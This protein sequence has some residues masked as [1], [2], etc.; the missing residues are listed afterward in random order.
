MT[1]NAYAKSKERNVAFDILKLVAM[2]MVVI[3]H[4]TGHGMSEASVETFSGVYWIQK[5]LN[6]FSMVAVNCFVLISGYFLSTKTISMKRILSLYIQVWSY[7]LIIYL[8]FCFIPG[9]NVDFSFSTLIGHMCPLLS[10]QYWFFTCYFLMYLLVPILNKIVESLEHEEYKKM[11][12]TLLFLFSAIPSINIW[13]DKFGTSNGYSLIWFVVLYLIA[14]YVRKFECSCKYIKYSGM[15]Y[16]VSCLILV[17]LRTAV[18]AINTEHG[19]IQVLLGNQISY[20]GPLVLLASV[21]LLL[22]AKNSRLHINGKAEK[23]ITK[24]SSL[25]FGIYLLHENNSIRNVLWNDWVQLSNVSGN[26]I[27]FVARAFVT[28][29][30]L[31]IAGISVEFIRQKAIVLLRKIFCRLKNIEG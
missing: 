11:L 9:V 18:A 16:V 29:L 13:G 2:T 17:A 4:I 24:A 28:L 7:S 8:V 6:T 22:S 10:G 5:I 25:S 15:I 23:L 31:V 14:A 21:C 19:S 3:L 27:A 26:C 1:E 30:V 20:N 12:V